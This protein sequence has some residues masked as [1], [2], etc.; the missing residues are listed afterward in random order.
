ME[1]DSKI[2]YFLLGLGLGVAVGV[3]F[4]PKSGAET[5]DL[6]ASKAS[7][8]SDY[9]KRRAVELRDSAADTIDRGKE[10]LRQQKENLSAAVEAGKQAYR[11][12]SSSPLP[13]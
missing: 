1:D 10:A 7:D 4:A 6:I 2:P 5:R 13:E 11:S 8:S 3:L 9:V 12:A